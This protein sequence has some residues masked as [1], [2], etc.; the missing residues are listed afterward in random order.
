ML[1]PQFQ[2]V[3]QAPISPLN[4]YGPPRNGPPLKLLPGPMPRMRTVV[5]AFPS[6]SQAALQTAN[7]APPRPN[8]VRVQ[9]QPSASPMNILPRPQTC[10]SLAQSAGSTVVGLS[11]SRSGLFVRTVQPS[12]EPAMQQLRSLLLP[13]PVPARREP[14]KL[15]KSASHYTSP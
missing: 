2:P 3:L 14:L 8:L 11:I 6:Q 7:F 12:S 4:P 1:R 15:I 13:Q 9:T 5:S 10:H